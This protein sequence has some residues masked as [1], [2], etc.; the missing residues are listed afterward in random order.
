[1]TNKK[2]IKVNDSLNIE[3]T[4]LNSVERIAVFKPQLAKI[5]NENIRE[6]VVR[7]LERVPNNFFFLPAST[8]GKH[9]NVS[10]IG[11][12]GL[13]RHTKALCVVAD[14]LISLRLFEKVDFDCAI[15]SCILHDTCKCGYEDDRGTYRHDHPLL[16]AKLVRTIAHEMNLHNDELLKLKVKLIYGA[17]ETHMGQWT[18]D[19][20]GNSSIVLPEPSTVQ[21]HFVHLCDYI[22][23][24]RS[25]IV[26]PE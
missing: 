25:I 23:S 5:V 7:V 15:A 22:A 16:A 21:Q 8:T 13:V 18:K 19:Y 20:K 2:V 10:S 24:R 6:L 9:H 4:Q 17:I 26:N 12:G 14:E 3:T 11:E 1:M